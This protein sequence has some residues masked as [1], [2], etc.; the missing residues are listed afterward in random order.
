M[1]NPKHCETIAA[2]ACET[3]SCCD[4]CATDLWDPGES[5]PPVFDELLSEFGSPLSPG[6]PKICEIWLSTSGG[7]M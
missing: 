6:N 3:L 5:L 2:E 7:N 1:V 4:D